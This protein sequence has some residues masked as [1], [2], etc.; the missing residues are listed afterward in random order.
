MGMVK[1]RTLGM[2][3]RKRV[4]DL[5]AGAGVTN[6]QLHETHKLGNEENKCEDEESEESV[7]KNF[8]NDVAVE[9]AHDAKVS[10]TWGWAEIRIVGEQEQ[11]E[12]DGRNCRRQGLPQ[13]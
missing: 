4:S 7:T 12:Q 10:V 9:D 2:M 1:T 13:R 5:R 11:Q 3:Q 6:K 8:A